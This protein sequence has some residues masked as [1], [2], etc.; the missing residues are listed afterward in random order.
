MPLARSPNTRPCLHTN[1]DPAGSPRCPARGR[2]TDEGASCL[3]SE[4]CPTTAATPMPHTSRHADDSARRPTRSATPH[5]HP[6]TRRLT[7]TR[8]TGRGTTTTHDALTRVPT[9]HPST[10]R[11]CARPMRAAKRPLPL[12]SAPNDD[13]ADEWGA[14]VSQGACPLFYAPPPFTTNGGC[15]GALC[16]AREGMCPSLCLP[17]PDYMLT[18]R[19]PSPPSFART[20]LRIG[21]PPRASQSRHRS[22]A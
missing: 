7:P 22:V 12:L 11:P 16:G 18:G 14:G 2:E 8:P 21:G 20:R 5:T 3:N 4:A 6:T 15:A 17:A 10:L 13:D 9:P 19:A 1:R